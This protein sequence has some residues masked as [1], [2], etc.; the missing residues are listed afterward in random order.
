MAGGVPG[1][2]GQAICPGDSAALIPLPV[3]VLLTLPRV[4]RALVAAM[5]RG[6]GGARTGRDVRTAPGES[7]L[8]GDTGETGDGVKPVV[9][10]ESYVKVDTRLLSRP[11]AAAGPA[12]GCRRP[13]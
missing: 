4:T 3:L 12:T 5:I 10:M 8:P 6:S 9:A 11:T 13:V 2:M 1:G 7:M